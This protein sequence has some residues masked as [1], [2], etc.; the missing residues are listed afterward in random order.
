MRSFDGFQ[1]NAH[2]DRLHGFHEVVNGGEGW[3]AKGRGRNVVEAD[4]EGIG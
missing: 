2:A 3:R 1:Q 4:Q